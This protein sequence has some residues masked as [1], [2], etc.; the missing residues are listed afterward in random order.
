[1]PIHAFTKHPEEKK[2]ALETGDG[3]GELT[4]TLETGNEEGAVTWG[5]SDGE[6]ELTVMWLSPAFPAFYPLFSPLH[7]RCHLLLLTQP[8]H[9]PL[10]LH[11]FSKIICW[12]LL[13]PKGAS[14]L[15]K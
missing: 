8:K 11:I 1:M 5:T 3:E 12:L 2:P 15:S 4:V 9:I 10:E 13:T 7:K 14:C 6:E